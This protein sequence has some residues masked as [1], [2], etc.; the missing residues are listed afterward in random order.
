ML[1]FATTRIPYKELKQLDD[2]LKTDKKAIVNV[3]FKPDDGPV[4]QEKVGY[5]F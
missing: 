1:G 2:Y 3:S 5:E 4:L